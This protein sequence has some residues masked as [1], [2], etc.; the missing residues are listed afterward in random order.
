MVVGIRKAIDAAHTK[1]YELID[2]ETN[3]QYL[4]GAIRK[5][6]N[7]L[8]KQTQLLEDLRMERETLDGR[9]CD[10]STRI[11]T[12]SN[13]L[14]DMRKQLD[15]AKA[16]VD[17]GDWHDMAVIDGSTGHANFQDWVRNTSDH[18]LA[19]Y[20]ACEWKCKVPGYTAKE[21][22]DWKRSIDGLT[23]YRSY[24]TSRQREE[25]QSVESTRAKYHLEA[26]RKCQNPYIPITLEPL[27]SCIRTA[28]VDDMVEVMLSTWCP[29][30]Y[31]AATTTS[32]RA[33][34]HGKSKTTNGPYFKPVGSEEPVY[35]DTGLISDQQ[36]DEAKEA[37]FKA[38]PDA[39]T[40]LDEMECS[41]LELQDQL[42]IKTYISAVYNNQPDIAR[43]VSIRDYLGQRKRARVESVEA[44]G[45]N[46][47][48]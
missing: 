43:M 20:Q 40:F 39:R 26:L 15:A 13:S 6:A 11:A 22:L 12:E 44:K 4:E 38:D 10:T 37:L 36:Q 34:G 8:D 47:P 14:D 29:T 42:D 30:Q 25:V 17:K 48:R 45:C 19:H 3:I 23:K 46:S 21:F 24:V 41:E 31:G 18:L 16:A 33:K 7:Y 35:L 9:I 27:P 1:R 28:S 2:P 32:G 5:K